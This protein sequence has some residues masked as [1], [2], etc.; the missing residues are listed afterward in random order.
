MAFGEL[1]LDGKLKDTSSIFPILLSLADVLDG[2]KIIV[3]KESMHKLSK[4]P[5]LHLIAVDTLKEAIDVFAEKNILC[6]P[7]QAIIDAKT[8]MINNIQYYYQ[9]EF[10]ED[11]SDIKGQSRAIRAALI[12]ACGMHNILFEGSPGCGKSMSAKRLRYI[13]PPLTLQEILHRAKLDSLVGIEP[14]FIPLRESRAPHHSATKASVFGGGTKSAQIGEI[15]LSHNGILFFD[16]LPHFPKS[17]LEALRE[18]LQDHKVL[19]SRVNSKIEYKT[20]F[21]FIGA[22]NP[23]PCGNALSK[24]KECR[25]S[26]LEVKRYK[27]RLSSPFLDRIELYVQMQEVAIDDS[28]TTSSSLMYERVLLAFKR[29]KE[30]GQREL[31]GKL[32]DS[33][34]EKFCSLDNELKTLLNSAIIRYELSQRAINNIVKVARTIADIEDSD[35]I[36]KSHLLEALSFRMKHNE[37][38]I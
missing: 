19:V 12:S 13:L 25:C 2:K 31:N 17:I 26:D 30:R 23:C 5:A 37:E 21:L 15:A 14:E 1:G 38:G 11:F 20:K 28:A 24:H 22:M 35:M 34:I 36:L 4:I 7:T 16:E 27:S 32:S 33:E 18:P 8:I 29:Q 3:P 10:L 9:S 6:Q